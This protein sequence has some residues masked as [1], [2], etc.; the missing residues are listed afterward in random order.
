MSEYCQ[1]NQKDWCNKP[2]EL[3]FQWIKLLNGVEVAEICIWN[4]QKM[5]LLI[6]KDRDKLY[7]SHEGLNVF[8]WI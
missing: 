4:R 1:K 8:T 5:E 3:L 2:T 6:A 7:T